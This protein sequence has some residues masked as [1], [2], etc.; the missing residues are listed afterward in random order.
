[1]L[2]CK[3]PHLPSSRPKKSHNSAC[4]GRL[5]ALPFVNP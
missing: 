4:H 1:L 3:M 2:A 5:D